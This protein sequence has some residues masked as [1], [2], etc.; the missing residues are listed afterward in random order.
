MSPSRILNE[1]P[2]FEPN[3]NTKRIQGRS[4]GQGHRKQVSSD[5]VRSLSE[6]STIF[7]LTSKILLRKSKERSAMFMMIT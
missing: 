1:I 4:R 2:R 7:R 3:H 5:T 6:A